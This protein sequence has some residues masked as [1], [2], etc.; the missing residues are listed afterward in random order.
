VQERPWQLEAV[1]RGRVQ[2]VGF[3]YYV[4]DVASALG[5]VGWVANQRDGSVA[6]A[7]EGSREDLER[8]LELLRRGPVG[9]RVTDVQHS[10]SDATGKWQRFNVRSGEHRG[11]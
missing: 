6:C 2:G 7:A 8:L 1:V 3:R 10:W 11:D 4:L 9:A 5:L